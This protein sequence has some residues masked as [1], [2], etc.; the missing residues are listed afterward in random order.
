MAAVLITCHAESGQVTRTACRT[1]EECWALAD[2]AVLGW[3][4]R[5]RGYRHTDSRAPQASR[6]V[7]V[8]SRRCPFRFEVVSP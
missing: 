1:R 8:R 5:A 7:A 2:R 4:R 6:A 3:L